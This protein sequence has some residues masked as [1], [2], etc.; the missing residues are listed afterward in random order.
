MQ[1]PSWPST[2]P[3]TTTT[4][5]ESDPTATGATEPTTLPFAMPSWQSYATPQVLIA[6]T[7]STT[8][9]LLALRL[10]RT[11]LK[12]FTRVTAIPPSFYRRRALFG[13]CMRVGD[14]DGFRLLHTPGGRLA[15]WGWLPGKRMPAAGAGSRALADKTLSVRLAGIDAPEMAH[16]G[17]PA[18]AGS[19]EAYDWL[20]AYLTGRRVRVRVWRRDQYDRVVGTA[21]VRC[22][23]GPRRD[24]GLLMLK[25][26]LATVYEAKAGAEF[27]GKETE[28]LYREAERRARDAG[29]GIWK[30][31]A[32]AAGRGPLLWAKLT[33]GEQPGK[34]ESPRDFKNRTRQIDK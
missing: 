15:G 16:F 34:F 4:Q 3:S 19:R 6:S 27:G 18:Q 30:G 7:L 33:G 14:G 31:A 28:A 25:E 11:R 10:H 1:W 23:W 17:K 21:W 32:A 24:V 29:R 8:T 5:D 22:W 12:Q 9:L 13:R 2:A 26:G 20:A